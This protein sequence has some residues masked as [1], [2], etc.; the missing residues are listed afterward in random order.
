MKS[1]ILFGSLGFFSPI[2]ASEKVP[3]A[4]LCICR[5]LRP[6]WVYGGQLCPHRFC[7]V[8]FPCWYHEPNQIPRVSEVIGLRKELA[9]T[10]LLNQHII[11]Y[12]MY[13]HS[14]YKDNIPF[15]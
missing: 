6:A 4:L 11:P 2:I 15:P 3:F 1:Y 10:A 7:L 9:T 8:G 13:S 14:G 5:L 12:Y